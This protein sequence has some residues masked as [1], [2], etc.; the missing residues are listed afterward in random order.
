MKNANKYKF[1]NHNECEYFPCH[2][3][4]K[5]QETNFNCMFCYCPLNPYSNCGGNYTTL[6]NGWKDCSNCL[7]PHFNYDYIVNKLME[8]KNE[9]INNK[10]GENK[11]KE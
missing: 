2:R 11:W 3:I 6:P 5:H 10:G 1:F 7:L 9:E 4:P 8:L